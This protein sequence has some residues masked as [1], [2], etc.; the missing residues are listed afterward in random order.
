MSTRLRFVF[1]S[2]WGL[3]STSNAHANGIFYNE[4]HL[5]INL[6]EQV[7]EAIDGGIALT[8]ESEFAHI[9][10]FLFISWPEQVKQ[11]Q[12]TVTRHALSN[13]YLVKQGSG[14][15]PSMFRSK[16][17]AMSF[18]STSTLELFKRYHAQDTHSVEPHQMRL[19]LSISELP[20]PLRLSAF[21]NKEW[22]LDSGWNTWQSAQ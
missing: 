1:L 8:F 17:E 7:E 12:F 16:R 4:A 9:E 14:L 13:R 18:I 5:N 20:G 15:A 22:N 11:H 3:I 19:R 10:H 21:I 6:S 2:L